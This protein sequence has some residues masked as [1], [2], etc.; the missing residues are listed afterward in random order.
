MDLQTL[1]PLFHWLAAHP[2]WAG[3]F[4]FLIALTESLLV[5]GLIVPGTVL[6]FGVGALLGVGVLGLW[7]TLAW[8]FAGAVAGDG[9][10]FWLGYHF[11]ERIATWWPFRKRPELLSKGQ[12]FFRRHG[13][14]SVLFGR[15][16]GPVR[17]VIPA[18]AG[19]MQMPPWRFVA[20]NVASALL[21]APAYLLPG[22]AFGAS[23]ELAA[24]VA[25]RL[26]VLMLGIL[27]L[28][29]LVIWLVRRLV[30]WLTP[31]ASYLTDR[32]LA[33]GWSHPYLGRITAWIM[34]PAQPEAKGLVLWAGLLLVLASVL[35]GLIALAGEAALPLDVSVYNFLH[36][37]HTPWAN[38]WLSAVLL[39][40]D[41]LPL[42]GLA[43][44]LL[45]MLL[46]RRQWSTAWHLGVTV[47]FAVLVI[48]LLGEL[49]PARP[50]LV[51]PAALGGGF[52]AW[53]VLGPLTLFGFV[54]I[55]AGG[56]LNKTWR[57]LPYALAAA[58]VTVFSLAALYLGVNWLSDVV[59]AWVLGLAWVAVVGVAYRRRPH[60]PTRLAV[61]LPAG[62][63][64]YVGF[65][66]THLAE[67]PR[68]LQQ[69]TREMPP[70]HWSR[71]AWRQGGWAELEPYRRDLRGMRKQPLN[72]QWRAEL[73]QIRADLE[74]LGWHAPPPLNWANA[75]RW[76]SARPSLAELPL[77]PNVHQGRH[78]ALVLVK[79]TGENHQWLLRLWPVPVRVDDKPLWQGYVA[80]QGLQQQFEYFWLP[81]LSNDFQSPLEMLADELAGWSRQRVRWHLTGED[82]L[83]WHGEVL[84]IGGGGEE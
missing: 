11:R 12:A 15:F 79:P 55:V 27:V 3:I 64:A 39:W 36:D 56:M 29:V 62:L 21:W 4:V 44:V 73:T 16:V 26:A 18:V 2:G 43:G 32:L 84:L 69:M 82:A 51:H 10:S 72:L 67:Q 68:L 76:F 46:A 8:A 7:E 81:Q 45:L 77:L 23:M 65:G 6:M 30:R 38:T 24:E 13:G 63:L 47:L 9:I 48:A 71:A 74:R 75:L 66:F 20:V 37:L 52:P 19:M 57:W 59:A 60:R 70:A 1:Q 78:E 33:W 49:R 35:L 28:V 42:L 41:P 54:A 5:V 50:P 17:P 31:W 83:R 53:H 58:G 34:D 80:R 14:K 40:A 25:G 22:I 61:V